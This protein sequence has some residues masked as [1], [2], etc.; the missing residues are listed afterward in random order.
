[1]M[2][3][4]SPFWGEGSPAKTDYGEKGALILASLEGLEEAHCRTPSS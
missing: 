3:F 2:P 4:L 1:M